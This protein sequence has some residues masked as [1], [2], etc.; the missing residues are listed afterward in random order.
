MPAFQCELSMKN[1][2]GKVLH[3]HGTSNYVTSHLSVPSA[4][5]N[6]MTIIENRIITGHHFAKNVKSTK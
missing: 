4:S 3:D 5:Q 6:D 1:Y 2:F